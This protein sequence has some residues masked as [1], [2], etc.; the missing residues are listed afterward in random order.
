LRTKRRHK[1]LNP[2]EKQRYAELLKNGNPR[3]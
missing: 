3:G 1:Q 2:M